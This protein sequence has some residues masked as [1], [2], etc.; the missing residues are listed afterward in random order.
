[1]ADETF[2]P[3]K[4]ITSSEL[5]ESGGDAL[6]QGAA[7]RQAVAA[8][9][10]AEFS[11]PGIPQ[12]AS[13]PVSA[14]LRNAPEEFKRIVAQRK[15]GQMT[16]G[17]SNDAPQMAGSKL[18]EL[19]AGLQTSTNQFHEIVLP[20]LGKFYDG[21]DGPQ[22][23][24]LH[25]RPMTGEEEQIL[26]TPRLVRRGQ[27]INMIFDRCIREQEFRSESFL[28]PDRTFL[29]IFLRGI[30][31]T[32]DYDVEVRCPECNT[33][34]ATVIDLDAL[35]VDKCPL[36]FDARNLSG[37]LPTSGFSY[38]FRISRGIDEQHI[39]DYRERRLKGFDLSTQAD[40]TLLYRTAMLL[41]DLEGLNHTSEIQLVLKRLPINDVAH[42]RNEV[43]NQ[44]FGVDTN[45]AISCPSCF[46]E[47]SN[48]LPLEANFFFP[49][50]RKATT[51]RV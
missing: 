48:D 4:P 28:T 15:G 19:L 13:M 35:W 46:A 44:P 17:F 18:E 14:N 7:M 37:K 5:N 49:R 3:R 30:S 41:E 29:L 6:Q 21:T 24:K 11:E 36:D 2:R 1:M 31:Y 43:N 39:Q 23:G 47:F 51:T 25:I 20:S 22:D 16:S 33:K 40:D 10:G 12:S 50:A 38:R 26:A 27:A 34:F 8:E 32:K 42:L 45:I 9:V